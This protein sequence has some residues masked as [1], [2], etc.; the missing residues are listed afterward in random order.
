MASPFTIF[1]KHQKILIAVLGLMAMGA[2]VFLPIILKSIQSG[3]ERPTSVVVSTDEFGNLNERQIDL[4]MYQRQIVLRF[5]QQAIT[6][7]AGRPVPF[8]QLEQLFGPVSEESVVQSWLMDQYAGQMGMQVSNG[9]LNQFIRSITQD[10]LSGEELAAI[11]KEM[12]ISESRLFEALRNEL[13][14]LYF[15]RLYFATPDSVSVALTASTPAQ[16]WEYFE[17]LNR[18]AT[19]QMIA[20]PVDKFV[21]KIED[22]SEKTLK[23]FFEK[24]KTDYANPASPEPGFHQPRRVKV[25]YVVAKRGAFVDPKAVTEEEIKE[26]YE[27]NKDRYYVKLALPGIFDDEKTPAE[28]PKTEPVKE[29][30]KKAET[31][32]EVKPAETK[33]AEAEKK[34]ASPEKPAEKPADKPAEKKPAAEKPEKKPEAKPAEKPAETKPAET[35]P[36]ETRPAETKPAETKPAEAPKTDDKKTSTKRRS[37]FQLVSDTKTTEVKATESDAPKAENAD[38]EKKDDS[39]EYIPLDEVKDEIREILAR[40]QAT[41]RMQNAFGPIREAMSEFRDKWVVADAMKEEG[42]EAKA[43]EVP[44]PDLAAMAKKANLEFEETPLVDFN[45]A[46]K[47]PIAM[48]AVDG[49]QAFLRVVFNERYPQFRPGL[50]EDLEGSQYLFWIVAE[51]AERVPEFDEEGVRDEVAKAWK[52]IEARKLAKKE[53]ESLIE[54][55][56]KAN[57]SLK[58]E[59]GGTPDVE[60]IE[61]QPFSWLTRGPV[62]SMASR[63]PPRISRVEGVEIP[64]RDFMKSIFAL[65]PSDYGVAMNNPETIAYAVEMISLQTV[66][67]GVVGVVPRG[68]FQQIRGCRHRRSTGANHHLA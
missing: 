29:E 13:T 2:F 37:P 59:F 52:M 55:A 56:K 30:P 8:Q 31:P 50:S 6:T 33:P 39:V 66:V 45:A 1:R 26:Y 21:S 43:E 4:L 65:A 46:A 47:L 62:P 7:A 49:A 3:G 32:A 20:V 58:D 14:A 12:K 64:G 18:R 28:P 54:K 57:K 35:K 15:E 10:Q 41:T 60:V 24:Y 68:R 61:P 19:T 23:E 25:Q 34:A 40:E 67:E 38:A 48:S 51:E 53:A 44:Q 16:R 11:L 5:I 17:R 22:P 63:Q 9:I 42:E 36:A 27:A